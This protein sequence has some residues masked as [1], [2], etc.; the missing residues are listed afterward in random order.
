MNHLKA[1][2]LKR[3]QHFNFNGW[4]STLLFLKFSYQVEVWVS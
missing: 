3:E 1:S 2:G 4:N